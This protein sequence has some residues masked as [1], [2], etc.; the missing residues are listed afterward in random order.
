MFHYIFDFRGNQSIFSY[1][2]IF[3]PCI[4]VSNNTVKG[5]KWILAAGKRGHDE[6]VYYKH[7]RY[8]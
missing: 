6:I 4:V 5:E 8:L 2:P 3:I 7:G 1:I